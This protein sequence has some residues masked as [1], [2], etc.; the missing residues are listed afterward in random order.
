[1]SAKIPEETFD[2]VLERIAS[3]NTIKEA[4]DFVNIAPETFYKWARDTDNS[5]KLARAREAR[6]VFFEEKMV[7]IGDGVLS[8]KY[9]PEQGKGAVYIYEK[10]LQLR[11]GKT[12]KIQGDKDSP[13]EVNVT[14]RDRANA[15]LNLIKSGVALNA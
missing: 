15:V 7:E 14:D 6:D 4:C 11:K 13:L 5:E 12:I 8:E 1:M 9:T 3:G 10:A 2:H